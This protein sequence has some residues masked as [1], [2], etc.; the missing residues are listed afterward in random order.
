[1]S[2]GVLTSIDSCSSTYSFCLRR[3][4]VRSVTHVIKT[5]ILLGRPLLLS[6]SLSEISLG[7][8]RAGRTD[9]SSPTLGFEGPAPG[10][11]LAV[12]R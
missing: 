12:S 8:F 4:I 2:G 10:V 6:S 5:Y 1:M 3:T 9:A 11:S 7:V